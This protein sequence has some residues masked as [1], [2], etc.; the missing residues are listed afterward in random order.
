MK[1]ILFI[2][3]LITS[4]LFSLNWSKDLKTAFETSAKTGKPLMIFIEGEYCRWCKKM[5]HRTLSDK[6]IEKR[7]EKYV[8]VKVQ[9]EDEKIKNFLPE[10]KGI[11]TV[12]FMTSKKELLETAIG[13]WD[14][15]DF[16]SYI[17]D[18]EVKL[19]KFK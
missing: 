14:V 11:P 15:M 3:I 7:L 16:S 12:F 13:Y 9:R 18:V 2:I 5:K 4:T 17:D 19:K 1:K 10:I 8:V 6:K